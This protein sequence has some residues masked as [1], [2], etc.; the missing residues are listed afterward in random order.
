MQI[1]TDKTNIYE[2]LG[3]ISEQFIVESWFIQPALKLLQNDQNWL[4]WFKARLIFFKKI[5][6][7]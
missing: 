7:N 5:D 1:I 4:D 6:F 2:T 3:S